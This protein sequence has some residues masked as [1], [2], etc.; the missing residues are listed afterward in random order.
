MM[1][2]TWHAFFRQYMA[3]AYPDP[4]D[5]F[6]TVF[7]LMM[8]KLEEGKEGLK[9][10]CPCCE[11]FVAIGRTPNGNLALAHSPPGCSEFIVAMSSMNPFVGE[12][13]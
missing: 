3:E 1:D 10:A 6:R 7:Q 5:R 4:V 8:E 11:G 12:G 13:A 9:G 2:H